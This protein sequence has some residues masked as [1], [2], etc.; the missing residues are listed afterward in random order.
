M[1]RKRIGLTMHEYMHTGG[2][3]ISYQARLKRVLSVTCIATIENLNFS[4]REEPNI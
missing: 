4:L 1:Y 2:S 3:T